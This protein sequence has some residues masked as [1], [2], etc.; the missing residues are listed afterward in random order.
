SIECLLRFGTHG[1]PAEVRRHHLQTAE[2]IQAQASGI[3]HWIA[4]FRQSPQ[5]EQECPDLTLIGNSRCLVGSLLQSALPRTDHCETARRSNQRTRSKLI[6]RV[7][8]A[9]V[10]PA[11]HPSVGNGR[12]E[13][14]HATNVSPR[15]G[16]DRGK[17]DPCG[18]SAP[19]IRNSVCSTILEIAPVKQWERAWPLTAQARARH[20][21][22]A[23]CVVSLVWASALLD[24]RHDDC[25]H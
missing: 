19:D 8:P 9:Y 17:R 1:Q 16:A 7:L 15:H 25:L 6:R 12:S 5:L 23:H 2:A 3:A 18:Q 10:Q 11:S 13:R 4:L 21:A 24:A 20:A 22:G 14:L